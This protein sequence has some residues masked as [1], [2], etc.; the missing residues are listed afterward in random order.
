M[1]GIQVVAMIHMYGTIVV[2]FLSCEIFTT[3]GTVFFDSVIP[4]LFLMD[5]SQKFFLIIIIMCCWGFFC[6]GDSGYALRPWVMTPVQGIPEENPGPAIRRYN[7]RH[8]QTRSL[9]ERCNGL[10]KMRFRCLLKHRVLHYRPD[11]CFRIINACAVLHNLWID[12][13][14][15]IPENEDEGEDIDFGMYDDDGLQLENNEYNRNVDLMAG[16]RIRMNV[17]RQYFR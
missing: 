8:R 16:R 10:L 4:E 12:N 3:M 13:D 11:K 2:F 15:P 6:I 17:I 9:I 1:Q 14:I 7:E 5:F